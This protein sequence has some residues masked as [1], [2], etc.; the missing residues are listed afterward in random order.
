LFS[1]LLFVVVV[2]AVVVVVVEQ[3]EDMKQIPV[4]AVVY[5]NS[6]ALWLWWLCTQFLSHYEAY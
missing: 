2:A 5:S 1:P 6:E 4:V 3:Q